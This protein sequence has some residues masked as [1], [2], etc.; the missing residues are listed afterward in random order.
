MERD[1]TSHRTS[2]CYPHNSKKGVGWGG[3]GRFKICARTGFANWNKTQK[4]GLQN[5]DKMLS[6]KWL[7]ILPLRVQYPPSTMNCNFPRLLQIPLLC[8]N[9]SNSF[10][11][12]S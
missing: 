10:F 4:E 3:R 9:F 1:S 7:R 8:F 2:I 12:S 11:E 5:N 6:K